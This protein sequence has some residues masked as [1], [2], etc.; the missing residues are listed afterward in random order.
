M[1]CRK[2]GGKRGAIIADFSEKFTLLKIR[3]RTIP[4]IFANY[5]I[6]KRAF[7]YSI[8]SHF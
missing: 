2:K 4:V 8:Y 7:R 6:P 5:N 3:W 1:A